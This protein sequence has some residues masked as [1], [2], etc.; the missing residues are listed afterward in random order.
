M[1]PSRNYG[2]AFW[3]VMT[4]R[5]VILTTGRRRHRQ[6]PLR[7]DREQRQ[8]HRRATTVPTGALVGPT[9][10]T[11][12]PHADSRH[13]C[14]VRSNTVRMDGFNTMLLRAAL[15]SALMEMPHSSCNQ[16]SWATTPGKLV[17]QQHDP[18]HCSPIR[19][20]DHSFPGN[21]TPIVWPFFSGLSTSVVGRR[22]NY[23][24]GSYLRSQQR[25]FLQTA[26]GERSDERPRGAALFPTRIPCRSPMPPRS[27]LS[28]QTGRLRSRLRR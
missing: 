18:A 6:Q 16:Y 13:E 10:A 27:A 15:A 9:T 4:I 7:L 8:H 19:R 11:A 28:V 14:A 17:E 22:Y 25:L 3:S 24:V 20:R 1:P 21:Q 26:Q 12:I 23:T 5:R 2:V